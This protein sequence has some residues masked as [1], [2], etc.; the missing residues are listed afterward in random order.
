MAHLV[1]LFGSGIWFFPRSS[2][3]RVKREGDNQII[4]WFK[5]A[6]YP[7]ITECMIKEGEGFRLLGGC[8]EIKY[9]VSVLP[10]ETRECM[11]RL[12]ISSAA[13]NEQPYITRMMTNSVLK[14]L[15]G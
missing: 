10:H 8:R 15:T 1:D 5:R 13:A 11:L 14:S 9:D 6:L 7:L 4:I 12:S 2:I 3:L